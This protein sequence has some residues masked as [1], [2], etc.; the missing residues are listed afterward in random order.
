MLVVFVVVSTVID[1]SN[2]DDPLVTRVGTLGFTLLA[3]GGLRMEQNRTLPSQTVDPFII[4][5][6]WVRLC[7]YFYRRRCPRCTCVVVPL[8]FT[9]PGRVV[10][11]LS[12]HCH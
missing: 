1:D 2:L 11:T 9:F 4:N 6:T 10:G 7:K 12:L 8:V 3:P 5:G